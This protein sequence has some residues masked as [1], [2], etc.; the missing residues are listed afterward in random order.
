MKLKDTIL[1]QAGNFAARGASPLCA[2]TVCT[3]CV[4]EVV[5]EC[6]IDISKSIILAKETTHS[7]YNNH[8]TTEIRKGIVK[9]FVEFPNL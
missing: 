9:I 2:D 8:I 4:C 7:K 1:D 3:H 5:N 6:E